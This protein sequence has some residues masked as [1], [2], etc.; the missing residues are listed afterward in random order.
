VSNQDHIEYEEEVQRLA[1]TTRYIEAILKAAETTKQD[2]KGN[3]KEAM[4]DLDWVDSSLSYINVLTNAKFLK[5]TER[6]V[7]QLN[8]IKDR[9]YFA[10]MDFQA[11]NQPESTRYYI[12]KT[13]LY[14]KDDQEP[15]IVDWRSPIA[16]LYYDGR[17]GEISYEAEGKTYQGNLSLKRQYKIEEGKLQDYRDIDI[18]TR[19]ELLQ[20]SLAGRADSRLTEIVS[21]IQTEQNQVIR[22]AMRRPLI[23]QGVAGSGKTTIAL[24]RMAYLIYTYAQH[25]TPD[26]LMILAPNRLFLDYIG[27]VL[28]E[29]G[30]DLVK[31]TTFVD[32]VQSSI[33]KVYRVEP[34]DHKLL[35]LIN[36]NDNEKN[37][38]IKW[39]SA[40]KGSITFKQVID[41]YLQELEDGMIPDEDFKL[42]KKAIVYPASKIKQLFQKEYRYLPFLKRL[43]KIKK[44]LAAQ[45]KT[46]KKNLLKDIEE[47]YDQKIDSAMYGIRDPDQRRP[48]V[49]MLMDKKERILN[50]VKKQSRI[51]VNQ[52]MKQFKKEKLMAY[53]EELLKPETFNRLAEPSLEPDR[54]R[55]LCEDSKQRF[56]NKRVEFEDLAPLLYLQYHLFGLKENENIQNVVIDE[57]QDYSPFQIFALKHVLETNAFT[58]LGDLSQGIHGYRGTNDWQ[59]IIRD[60]FPKANYMTL[61]QSYRTTVEIMELANEVLKLSNTPEEVLA[62]PVVR[63]GKKP[64]FSQFNN[65]RQ[66]IHALEEKIQDI[67]NDGGPSI[68]IIAKTDNECLQVRELL[69]KYHGHDVAILNHDQ[70]I[71][72]KEPV[73]VPAYLTKGLEFD[74]VIT[75]NMNE[76]YT[77]D[78]LDLK[79]LYVVFTRAMHRLEMLAMDPAMVLL[80]EINTNTYQ[81]E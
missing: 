1:A 40:Y 3:I 64:S 45:L 14:E 24:H 20:E 10:R 7:D 47:T 32:F 80:D 22:A 4:V 57:A 18:T 38:L 76:A 43:D 15:I 63:H 12:G 36:K 5:M 49:V 72:I 60:V 62:K 81:S 34:T 21:T 19:D 31:Q 17:L 13:S 48:K 23:V 33:N 69:K 35:A 71:A 65:E 51:A 6:Q 42:G 50:N 30:V 66:L 75:V 11:K 16:N 26:Q 67:R 79:L 25:F 37:A 58:I 59:E 46:K 56:R 52:Y 77:T 55:F 29:L 73:I 9:P 68:A 39:A 61:N 53:Y 74:A 70:E 2:Y 78:E 41:A 28:P 54:L 27:D 44:V 8:A